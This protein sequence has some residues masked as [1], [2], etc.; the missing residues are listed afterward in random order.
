LKQQKNNLI[1]PPKTNKNHH[2]PKFPPENR[3]FSF[4]PPTPVSLIFTPSFPVTNVAGE[5]GG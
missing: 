5:G 4:P 3:F 1:K 2:S